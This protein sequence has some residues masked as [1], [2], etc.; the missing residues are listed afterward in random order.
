MTVTSYD[1]GVGTLIGGYP[2]VLYDRRAAD[3]PSLAFDYYTILKN[4]FGFADLTMTNTYSGSSVTSTVSAHFALDLNNANVRLAF[5]PTED[6][7]TGTTTAYDQHNYYSI[8]WNT[9]QG[10]Q[11]PGPLHG[12]GHQWENEPNPILAANMEFNH[13]ARDIQGAFTGFPNTF[14]T[15]I[16]ANGTQSYTFNYTVPSGSF[17]SNMKMAA[18]LIDASTGRVLN[19]VQKGIVPTGVGKVI[20]PASNVSVYPN[21]SSNKFNVSVSV[22]TTQNVIVS[23]INTLGQTV[24][25]V[26]QV[27]QN[28][29][30]SLD[31]TNSPAGS[32]LIKVTS[33]KGTVVKSVVKL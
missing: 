2:T 8:A 24:A 7:V 3:D 19:A 26:N 25:T 9:Q 18:I 10:F 15:A 13:V 12:A 17:I 14:T 6:H 1:A 4:E 22:E 23:A 33:A 28:G 32:Y 16:T 27:M 29:V 11:A 20:E 5:V 21:P 30:V 31:L